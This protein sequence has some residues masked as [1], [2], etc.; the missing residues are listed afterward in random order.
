ME[1]LIKLLKEINSEIDYGVHNKLIDEGILDSFAIMS[2]VA[3]LE[4]AYDIEISFEQITP[5]NFNSA[6]SLWKMVEKL[7]EE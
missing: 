2:L 5:E 3:E 1:I 6:R 7:M 4:E